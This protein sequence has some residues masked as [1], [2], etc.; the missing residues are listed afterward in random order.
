MPT[1]Q[2]CAKQDYQ[3]L[4]V[5]GMM[6]GNRGDSLPIARLLAG[7]SRLFGATPG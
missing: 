7:W 1:V 3:V 6:V 4:I 5:T 2:G